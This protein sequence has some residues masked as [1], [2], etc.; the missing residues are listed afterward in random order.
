MQVPCHTTHRAPPPG[1]RQAPCQISDFIPAVLLVRP[2][3]HWQSRRMLGLH[4][5]QS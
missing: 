1:N 4:L 5:G 3:Q 2:G